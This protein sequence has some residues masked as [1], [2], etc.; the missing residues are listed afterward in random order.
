MHITDRTTSLKVTLYDSN[1]L[2]PWKRGKY[3]YNKINGWQGLVRKG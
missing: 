2:T 1:Y 3:G